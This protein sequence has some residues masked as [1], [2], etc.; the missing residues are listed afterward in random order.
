MGKTYFSANHN[1]H[2]HRDALMHGKGRLLKHN[3]LLSGDI[4]A[5]ALSRTNEE[6]FQRTRAPTTSKFSLRLGLALDAE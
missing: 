2:N 5:C 4:S 6:Q 1:I 3:S